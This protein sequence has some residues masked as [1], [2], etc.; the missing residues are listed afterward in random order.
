MFS[1]RVLQPRRPAF[2]PQVEAL[3]E[4]AVPSG[5][6]LA[7]HPGQSI[8]AAIDNATPGTTIVIDPGVYKEALTVA[9]PGLQIVGK[10]GAHGTGVV[11]ENP[12]GQDNGVTVTANGFALINVTVSDFGENGVLLTGVDHFTLAAVNARNDG[13]YGLFP[14]FSQHGVIA[15]CQAS[16]SADTG[17]YVGQSHDVTILGNVAHDNVIGIEVENSSRVGVF[18]NETYQNT[19]GILVDLLPDLTVTTASDIQIAGNYVHDNNHA[20]FGDPGSLEALVP[21]GTGILVLGADR[22]TVEGNLVVRN[23]FVGI[24]VASTLLLAQLSGDPGLAADINASIEPNPDH[25]RVR[26]NVVLHNG[27]NPPAAFPVSGDLLWDGS[28]ID[29][30]W[31]GNVFITAVPNPLPS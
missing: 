5:N 15:L 23:Q 22:V 7:V 13:E 26:N 16:G 19:A 29:N 6:T 18:G 27:G 28:G 12:G 9:T 31:D 10:I 2:R 17:I 11:I 30:H 3:E 20:N 1:K 21:S 25:T 14:V 4:R 8:Q 24:G